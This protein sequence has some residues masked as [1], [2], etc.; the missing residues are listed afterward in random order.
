MHSLLE[1]MAASDVL[2]GDEARV[3]GF[4]KAF[5]DEGRI[6]ALDEKPMDPDLRAIKAADTKSAMAALMG[7]ANTSYFGSFFGDGIAADARAPLKY[8]VYI[9]QGGLGLPDRDYYL[10]ASFAPQK[11]KYEAY[12]AQMLKAVDW[13]DAEAQAK[14]VVALETAIAPVSWTKVEQR[15]P[16]AT[17]NAM[18]PAELTALA[19][20][21]DWAAYFAASDLG[22]VDR[23][24]VNEKT[25]FPKIAAIF[26]A[27][28]IATL[29]AWQAFNLVDGAS[30]YLSKR[31]ADAN[32]EFRNKVMSGQSVQ[33]P[34]WKR[35]VAAVNA[36]VGESVG[37]LYVAQY[38]PPES[39]ATMEA[40]IGDLRVALA[41]RISKVT[42]DERRHQGQGAGEALHAERQGRISDEVAGLQLADDLGRRPLR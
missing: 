10:Q 30:P 35:A 1:Q 40:L 27:T 21:F 42:W 12:V 20:G 36:G 22:S 5:M 9:G 14:A 4:Y 41:A 31:F 13:P 32:F 25:A 17:Y 38:F 26:A 16:V 37:K 6:E 29:Q 24:V 28:P 19:P 2:G 7:Q 8:A 15:D 33:K 3:G 23:V 39:K 11:A 18:T 34:R